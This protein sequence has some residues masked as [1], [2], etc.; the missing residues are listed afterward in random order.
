MTNNLVGALF[1]LGLFE[2][3]FTA[4]NFESGKWTRTPEGLCRAYAAT[5]KGATVEVLRLGTNNLVAFR[6]TRGLHV[7]ICGSVAAFDEGFEAMGTVTEL[8]H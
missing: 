5:E 8:R 6:A 4:I 7:T 1:L 3:K 2:Q